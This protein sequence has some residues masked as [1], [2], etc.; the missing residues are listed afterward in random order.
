MAPSAPPALDRRRGLVVALDG[1]GSSGKSSVGAAAALE[2]GYR[3]C[4][5]GLLYRAVTWL[6]LQRGIDPGDVERLVTLVDEVEL[7]P[8][9]RGRLARVKVDGEDVTGEVHGSEVDVQV[10][11]VAKVPELRAGLLE[12]QRAI[13][14]AGRIIVAGRDIGTVVLPN[15]DLKIFLNA[16]ADERARRRAEERG[17]DPWGPEA[18]AVL[19]ELRRRD[20]LDST[21]AVAPL[22]PAEDAQIIVTDGN[23]FEDTVAM[24]VEA[25]RSAERAREPAKPPAQRAREPAKPQAKPPAKPPAAQPPAKPPAKP[26]VAQAP[27]V[28]L[29]A[30]PI[31][32]TITPLIRL[33]AWGSRVVARSVVRLRI[34]GSMDAIPREGPVILAANHASN[35]DP[36]VIGA[37]LT[38]RLGRRIHWLG[39]RE[40]FEWPVVGWVAAH[41]GVHPVDRSTADLEAFR[42]A[43][44]ILDEGHVLMVFPEGTRSPDGVLQD[45]KDGVAML[46]LWTG[47][48]I[49]PI[50]MG[51]TDRFWPRGR[52]I[53]HVGRR[54]VMRIGSPFRVADEIPAGLDRRAAKSAAT[55][56][57]MARIAALLPARQRGAHEA[58]KAAREP[59]AGKA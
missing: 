10:S 12:R 35:A 2:L 25:V 59:V 36:V 29:E 54:I 56:L 27:H 58:P 48:P 8:D 44:R 28:S 16:S 6:A 20:E 32:D 24:V 1:P 55:A 13:A 22:R 41:G 52:A 18:A 26:P 40:L 4:D 33:V 49:V 3:F 11:A 42:L 47:A 31:E 39:K 5:T 50:G 7:A 38:P 15:A 45:A 19:A 43:R 37:W 51:D 9:D 23:R 17:L 46:A 30:A 34:E 14:R 53:P 57:I 21:R